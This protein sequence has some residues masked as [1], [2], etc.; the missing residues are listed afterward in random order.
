MIISVAVR[1]GNQ[2]YYVELEKGERAVLGSDKKDDIL[3]PDSSPHY[4]EIR[5]SSDQI[6]VRRDKNEKIIQ[7]N[8]ITVI[9][10]ERHVVLYASII[11][12][13][14]N[15]LKLPQ[16]GYL[17]VGRGKENSVTLAYPIISVHHFFIAIKDG[18]V[19]VE[20]L[21]STNHIY[22]NGKLVSKARMESGDV[23]S[24]YTFRFI[25]DGNTLHFD[26]MGSA[27]KINYEF[28]SIEQEEKQAKSSAEYLVYHTS[29]R[30]REQMPKET[31]ILSAAP[32]Q[33]PAG[34]GRK[35]NWAYLIG[36]G[37]MMA[38]S[39]A[40]GVLSPVMLLTRLAG[41]VS[42]LANMAMFN[43]MSKE[44]QAE[45]LEYERLRQ[46][47]YQAYIDEQKARINKI[48][49]TQRRIISSENQ[50]P[51]NCINTAMKMDRKLWE[52]MS[53]DSDFLHTRLGIG[54]EK[55]CVEV[56]T[57]ADV[58]GFS[59]NDDDEIEKLSARI[60][61]ETRF[62]DKMPVRADLR[63]LQTVGIVGPKANVYYQ[64]RAMLIELSA[65][66]SFKD[67]RMVG[68]F[69]KEDQ[70]IWGIL[71]WIPHFSD[72]TGQVRYLAFNDEQVHTI[73]EILED[74]IR[75][76]KESEKET[77]ASNKKN[78]LPHFVIIAGSRDIL[79]KETIYGDLFENHS[80][81]G[82]TTIVLGKELYDL[83][84]PCQY[85]IDLT[86][87][88]VAYEREKYDERVY[89]QQDDII[90]HKDMEEFARRLAA[91]ELEERSAEAGLPSSVTFLQGYQVR[92]VEELQIRDRWKNS[93][94]F[95]TLEAPIGIMNGG[96]IFSLNIRSGDQ[97]HGPH[98]L[99][100]GTTG[101]GKSELLQ[102][103]ILSMAVNYHPHDVNFVI[104]DYKGGGMSD[105]M[106]PLPHVVGEIT[107]IDR[108]IG[109]SLVSL[110]SELKRRERLFAAAGVNN[111]DKY[112]KAFHAGEVRERLPHLVIVTDEFAELK[113]EEPEFMAE[114]NSVATTGRSLGIH[115]L[116]ATQKPA[117]VVNDQINSNSRFRICMKVQDVADSRE[118]LKKPDA[119]RIT[120]AGRAYIRVGED[121]LFTLFQS[122]YSA[123]EYVGNKGGGTVRDNRVRI[124]G[125]TGNRINP[126]K[127]K[128]Q[129][130]LSNE[131][132][133]TAV[134]RHIN[135]IC[136]NDGIIKMA[137]PW[138]PELPHWLPLTELLEE[139]T[140]F[141][142][143][144]WPVRRKGL[145][146]PFGKYDIPENQTQGTLFID[147]A[148]TGHY[149]VYG[150][151][152]TGKTTLLKTVILSLG[153]NYTP[154]DVRITIIDA[155]S[156]SLSE[157]SDMPH[158][159]D[160]ILNQEEEKLASFIVKLNNEME[161]RKRAF[162][163]AAVNSLTAYKETVSDT[164]PAI[165]IVVDQIAQLFEQS[166]EFAEMMEKIAASGATYGIY[167]LFSATTSIGLKYKFLQMIKGAIT[168]QMSDKSDYT[169]IVGPIAGI[170]LPMF[171]GRALIRG[172]PPVAFHTAM[173][174]DRE[175]DQ[176]RHE[177]LI[178]LLKKMLLCS[179]EIHASEPDT[180]EVEPIHDSEKDT[181]L[182]QQRDHL[183]LGINTETLEQ[184]YFVTE[185]NGYILVISTS[186][187]TEAS[188]QIDCA[189]TILSSRED[190]QI[191]RLGPDMPPGEV[192]AELDKLIR[193]LNERKKSRVT[194]QNEPDFDAD[195]WLSGYTQICLLIDD[196][197]EFSNGLLSEQQKG[198]ARIFT[199]AAGLGIMIITAADPSLLNN[200]ETDPVLA[201]AVSSRKAL[202]IGGT[203]AEHTAFRTDIKD[204]R[205]GIT[206]EEEEAAFFS[207]GELQMIRLT[208]GGRE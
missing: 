196:L 90:H 49:D 26:N 199:M 198:F 195:Q 184:V 170:S 161:I 133:L 36:S 155:G 80:G 183:P 192:Q 76:R 102:T 57:R 191:I 180:P 147:F 32:G 4:L 162:L 27:L 200:A 44:E 62:V 186:E 156:W 193:I 41:M 58:D 137:G 182:Y 173:Y 95:R 19:S 84:Q 134:I 60:I 39:L 22:L 50:D 116:L 37:A 96:K 122:F 164:L 135:D 181:D 1:Y 206:M 123:A 45:L 163:K 48:A 141:D 117:G 73:C 103:W 30:L 143:T 29:P 10:K 109:R 166:A 110:K 158:V 113:K 160:V 18:I 99:L 157:F 5:R 91:I 126:V 35:G 67:L 3:V 87:K 63:N 204:P 83:P 68:L 154:T 194:K 179:T 169:S 15:S 42:P 118:M 114:L 28:G 144:G 66:H 146:V 9:D 140:Y 86:D 82:V 153:L 40:T 175:D 136:K 172:N 6:L 65:Q 75:R 98:G 203:P 71:R 12:G 167:L 17:S 145:S 128:Q 55:L 205:L 70:S 77:S 21:L 138:L 69:K 112:Q 97:S 38:A 174:I 125:V 152:G 121:E 148:Q 88:P 177:E 24:I 202:A 127:K 107:N 53:Q 64:L 159:D 105:L 139:G 101:S 61:D 54:K 100:A 201:A 46:E 13:R 81:L 111:I 93:E 85:L 115:M 189:A 33:G 7:M 149:A 59:M 34:T 52:R 106:E 165:V 208:W 47:K 190:N 108:N 20:D 23:L 197:P 150:S 131:D 89:F 78:P 11:A 119:A 124:V 142:S 72:E 129:R 132:E 74:M 25:L 79:M 120:Q 14:T 94:P 171:Q 151:P 168:L 92:T 56:K 176:Q 31:I 178:L 2:E 16:N 104:I 43:K 130:D 207:Q 188:R 185:K 187:A 8:T 51:H